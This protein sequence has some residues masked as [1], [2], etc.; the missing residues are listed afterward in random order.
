[1]MPNAV[2]LLACLLGQSRAAL[3]GCPSALPHCVTAA[4]IPERVASL[5]ALMTLEE[6][7]AQ[8]FERYPCG[9]GPCAD[10][11]LEGVPGFNLSETGV[12]YLSIRATTNKTGGSPLA[13]L[14][15]RNA[16]AS[17]LVA[18]SRLGIPAAW[19]EEGLHS[20]AWGGTVFPSLVGLGAGWD[21]PL[22]AAIGAA[23][24]AEARAA[25]VDTV[26]S[27]EVN[28][29]DARS[30]RLAEAFSDD[31]TLSASLG[32]AM[33][34]GLQGGGRLP[35]GPASYLPNTTASVL[36]LA[37]HYAAYGADGGGLNSG[38]TELSNR[39]LFERF[40]KPW[41]SLA[42][43]GV[44]GVMVAHSTT[45]N[46]PNHANPYL[47]GVLRGA[48]GFGDG[49]VMTDDNNIAPLVSWGVA[50][51]ASHAAARAL[52]AGVDVDLQGG[53]NSSLFG[54]AVLPAALSSGLVAPAAVEMAARRV[55]TGKFAS[56]LMDAPAASPEAALS[57]LQSAPHRALAATAATQA[58]V[59]LINENATLPLSAAAVGAGA[60]VAVIGELGACPP[61]RSSGGGTLG[62]PD[63]SGCAA[64]LALVG[65][66]SL[67]NGSAVIVPTLAEALT[68][69]IAA[70]VVYS[71]GGGP[72]DAAVDEA[73]V[74]AA[75]AAAAAADAAVLVLG[76]STATALEN[77]DRDSLDLPGSQLALLSAVAAACAAATP[78][79]VPLVVV[80]LP[81]RPTTFG[82]RNVLLGNVTA[83]LV[84]WRPG[85]AGAA[86]LA[87]ALAGVAPPAGKL[88]QAWPR[89]VGQIGGGA[90]PW[91]AARRNGD[92]LGLN[93]DTGAG[94]KDCDAAGVCYSRYVD[95]TAMPLFGFGSG[96]LGYGNAR[97]AYALA[98]ALAPPPPPSCGPDAAAIALRVN[99]TNAGT[100]AASEVVQVYVLDPLGVSLQVRAWKRLAAFARTAPLAPGARAEL[101]LDITADDLAVFDDDMHLRVLAGNYT[102]SVG[103]DA[104]SDT[105]R[106]VIAV[107]D[108]AAAAA[109]ACL[110]AAYA[111]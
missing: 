81:G 51:N 6:Q 78:R 38:V 89:S 60:T 12:G 79:R 46:V 67:W 36:A 105:T 71:R 55:L 69:A 50:A 107:T 52:A 72:D 86:A 57:V 98:T 31:A 54:Y 5:L 68:A 9:N 61:T 87:D 106:A 76:D 104:A 73:A 110:A 109:N 18:S 49:I 22:A 37:K 103:S 59:L 34:R 20:G 21:A 19:E 13:N 1:M 100:A 88:P 30:G 25:G 83:L 80:L 40:L 108:D 47:L 48:L 65:P 96:L 41:R 45:L 95:Q 70:R 26:Y 33:V 97:F 64:R 102:V 10:A 35:G 75:A 27:P 74:A 8:L 91:S 2:L 99:V 62:D 17:S 58:L 16:V 66:Y 56:G 3:L 44:R 7:M 43:A 11:L 111:L 32:A 84:G 90:S 15:L 92:W 28:L 94:A 85:Q 77:N 4:P 42:A 93:D 29:F 53:T 14:R 39:T 24:A 63:V 101:A 23:I 82:P